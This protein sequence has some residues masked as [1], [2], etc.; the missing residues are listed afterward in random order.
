MGIIRNDGR[1][2]Y[3]R[4]V[5]TRLEDLNTLFFLIHRQFSYMDNLISQSNCTNLDLEINVQLIREMESVHM[6]AEVAE[7]IKTVV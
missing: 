3:G 1:I 2:Q 5:N 4:D 7:A 6:A